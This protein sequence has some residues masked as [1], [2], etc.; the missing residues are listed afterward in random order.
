MSAQNVLIVHSDITDII[1][2]PREPA[3]TWLGKAEVSA[4]FFSRIRTQSSAVRW[5]NTVCTVTSNVAED[6]Q[7]QDFLET[8]QV[9]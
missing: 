1:S 4:Q 9:L 2:R 8:L 3:G 7:F 6:L 5:L